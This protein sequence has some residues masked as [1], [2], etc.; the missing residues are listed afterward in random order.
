MNILCMAPAYRPATHT[1]P[2]GGGEISNRL[3]LEGLADRGHAVAV[4]AIN[5][6]GQPFACVNGVQVT[7]TRPASLCSSGSQLYA[8]VKY[9]QIARQVAV[10]FSPNVVLA[11]TGGLPVALRLSR[12]LKI[13]C[14]LLVRA[15][16]HFP[17]DDPSG[18]SIRSRV[19]ARLRQLILGSASADAVRSCQFL[20][21]NSDFMQRVCDTHAPDVS[22]YVVYPPLDVNDEPQPER[23]QVR[24]VAMIGTGEHKGT[25]IVEALAARVPEVAFT[26]LGAPDIGPSSVVD[27]NL[28]RMGWC[29]VPRLFRE[30]DVVLVP[31]LWK[32]PFG[33]VAVEGLAAGAIV[34]VS[35]I[36]GLPETVGYEAQLQVA[37]HSDVQ[38]WERKIRELMHSPRPFIDASRRARANIS[39][40]GVER[41]VDALEHALLAESGFK[42]HQ[43]EL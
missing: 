3:L 26:I 5:G 20:L 37:P 21:P 36:G 10:R 13:R 40:F 8:Y 39:R 25:K 33:R 22:S 12:I 1:G 4:V 34:L 29:D 9:P 32:E 42:T 6:S 31:S 28:T 19:A 30:V 38:A 11:A 41:Q 43:Q 23:D 18:Q 24:S 14:G 15:F 7:Q 27:G 2:V 17:E 35:N 16:E